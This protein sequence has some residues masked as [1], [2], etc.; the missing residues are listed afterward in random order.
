MMVN[1]GE[2]HVFLPRNQVVGLLDPECIDISEIELNI[3]TIA[4]NAIET[5]PTVKEKEPENFQPG[6]PLDFIT[7]TA[8]FAG[9]HKAK[10][11][12]FKVIEEEMK[13]FK[14]LCENIWMYFLRIQEIL[15][16]HP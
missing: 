3:M 10:L 5:P 13:A 4:V 1:L 6:I 11:Q 12:D 15:V 2:D 16:V 8:D 9:P 14:D 7:S